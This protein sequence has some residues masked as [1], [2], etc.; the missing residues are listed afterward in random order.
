MPGSCPCHFGCQSVFIG[1][2]FLLLVEP[3]GIDRW[4]L[5]QRFIG[6]RCAAGTGGL[7]DKTG[8]W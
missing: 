1:E 5:R 6:G 3:V 2:W 7:Q 8:P 4:P